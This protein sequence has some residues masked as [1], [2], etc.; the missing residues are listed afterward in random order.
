[1]NEEICEAAH[2]IPFSLSENFDINNGLLLNCILHKL[3]DKHYWS[4]NPDSLCVEINK[5]NDH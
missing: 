5:F 1:M 2:I 4:I 3:F